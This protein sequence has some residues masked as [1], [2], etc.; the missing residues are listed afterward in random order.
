MHNTA[1]KPK[2]QLRCSGMRLPEQIL[3]IVYKNFDHLR[4]NPKQ[5]AWCMMYYQG[6]HFACRHSGIDTDNPKY[7]LLDREWAGLSQQDRDLWYE[8][9]GV[10]V[11]NDIVF[12]DPIGIKPHVNMTLDEWVT[13]KT[14][15]NYEY[16]DLFPSKERVIDHLLCT[17]GNGLEWNSDGYLAYGRDGVDTAVFNDYSRCQKEVPEKIRNAV[18]E[19]ANDPRI[20]KELNKIIRKSDKLNNM[21]GKE[22]REM[23]DEEFEKQFAKRHKEYAKKLNNMPGV[24]DALTRVRKTY[25]K[26]IKEEVEE[27]KL[28]AKTPVSRYP[29]S[30]YSAMYN[31]PKNVHESYVKAAIE[32]AKEYVDGSV[33]LTGDGTKRRKPTSEEIKYAKEILKKWNK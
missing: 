19:V 13:F 32:I 18:L 31:M 9:W 16:S 20:S 4:K 6:I 15:P 12:K 24:K 28:E 33:Y 30:D 29:L 21:T 25:K 11:S 10:T 14:D 17:I 3:S 2:N 8:A 22:R 1:T 27:A 23:K 5:M 26:I 7:P